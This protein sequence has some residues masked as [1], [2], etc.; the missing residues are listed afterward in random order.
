[1]LPSEL[2]LVFVR[3]RRVNL[4]TRTIDRRRSLQSG[5]VECVWEVYQRELLAYQ[6]AVAR[7]KGEAEP[8]DPF[9]QLE[10]Q[11]YGKSAGSSAS[12][13]VP[14]ADDTQEGSHSR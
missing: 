5:C 8:M 3:K 14:S 12:A 1:M 4:Y 11:L 10:A 13:P 2:L 6:K 9:E 7:A